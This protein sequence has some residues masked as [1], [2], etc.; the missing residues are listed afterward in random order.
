[1]YMQ[2]ETPRIEPILPSAWDEVVLDALGAFPRGLEFVLSRWKAGGVDARGMNTLGTMAHHP[3]LAKAFLT[4]NAHVAGASTLSGRVRELLI[5]RI[6]WLRQAEYEFI[7]HVILGLR[8]GLTPE[9]VQRVQAGPDAPGW[10]PLD[11]EIVRAADDLHTHACIQPATWTGLAARFNTQQ[12]MD[13]VFLVGCYDVLAMAM[14]SFQTQLEPGVAGLD[15]AVRAR[16]Y[17][18]SGEATGR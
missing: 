12:M 9:E 18:G 1:M 16:M 17:A 3:A 15:P 5:L 2:S 13:L 11:A 4:F 10:D 14:R 8:A 7:Q 6:S